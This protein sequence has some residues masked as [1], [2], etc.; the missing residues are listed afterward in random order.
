M[1][2]QGNEG[3]KIEAEVE[4]GCL[5]AEQSLRDKVSG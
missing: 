1:A 2:E 4:A 3:V 5:N